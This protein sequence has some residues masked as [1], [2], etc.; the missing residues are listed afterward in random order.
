MGA[1][2]LPIDVAAPAPRRDTTDHRA[3]RFGMAHDLYHTGQPQAGRAAGTDSAPGI[4]IARRPDQLRTTAK[5]SPCRRCGSKI[6]CSRMSRPKHYEAEL[7][8]LNFDDRQTVDDMKSSVV[9]QSNMGV[10]PSTS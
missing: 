10:L 6:A 4:R 9:K 1:K 2:T 8:K 7:S 5:A 3:V